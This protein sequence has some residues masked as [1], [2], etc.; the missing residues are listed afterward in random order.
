MKASEVLQQYTQGRRDFQGVNLRGLSF[1]GQNLSGAD[2]SRADIRSTNFRGATLR[3]TKFIEAKAGLRERWMIMLL[4]VALLL[5]ALSGFCSILNGAFILIFHTSS[6]GSM[7]TG[8]VGLVIWVVSL[9][10]LLRQGILAAIATGAVAGAV[11]GAGAFAIDLAGAGAGAVAGAVDGAVAVTVVGAGAAAF[12]VAVAIDVAGAA[13]F[14]VAVAGAIAGAGTFA[15][16]FVVDGAFGFAVAVAFVFARAGAVAFAVAGAAAFIYIGV[17]LYTA[18][19]AMKGDEKYAFIRNFA[20]AFGAIG[21]TCFR[22]ADLTEADFT[23][24]VLKSTDFREANLTRTV[25]RRTEKL[26]RAR[27]GKSILAKWNVRELLVSGKGH[28]QNFSKVDLRGANLSNVDLSY[29]NLT[30]ADLS[31]ATL[32]QANLEGANLTEINAVGTDLT[33]AT[34]TAACIEAWNTDST[35]QLDEINCDYIYLL[36]HQQERRP[37]IGMFAPGEFTKLFQEVFN[38]VDLIFRDGVNWKAFVS[39]F[40]QVQVENENTELAIQS[41]ENKGD[42]VIVV[43]VN[44]ALD[45]N[46]EKIHGDFIQNYE[47]RLRALEEKYKA[48][49]QMKDS[50]IESYKRESVNMMEVTKLLASRPVNSTK[51]VEVEMNFQKEVTGVAGKVEGNQIINPKQSLADSA[52]EIQQLLQI[53]E[54]AYPS[55]LPAETQAEIEVAV[56]GIEKDPVLKE[57]VISALKAGSMEALKELLDN[58]YLNIL[59]A[60]SDGWRNPS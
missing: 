2:F 26:D 20:I 19:R 23:K 40:Q 9:I 43:K 50:Q 30:Q 45:A 29:A 5:A 18:R 46:K 34:L 39:A 22:G 58:P 15:G 17:S 6:L 56:R 42:G 21:G 48:Q 59:V 10:V 4:I 7:V 14:A 32:H 35:T 60:T 37:S 31:Q 55:N 38:T 24:A 52:V 41:I 53:L 44:A 54:H 8:W 13:A 51:N 57:R 33:Q 36:N 27:P 25:W 49:L 3:R 12:A 16:A 1:K 28:R 47:L 11:V